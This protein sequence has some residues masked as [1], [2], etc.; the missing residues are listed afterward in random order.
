MTNGYKYKKTYTLQALMCKVQ[1]K[2]QR[3]QVSYKIYILFFLVFIIRFTVEQECKPHG[4]KDG[5]QQVRNADFTRP[6]EVYTDAEDQ[7]RSHVGQVIDSTRCHQ[8][9]CDVC[10]SSNDPLRNPYR[11]KGE[12]RTLPHRGYHNHN[13]DA[14]E[15][16]F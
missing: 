15:D 2:S 6:D 14:V 4:Y 3:I 8:R 1:Q 12:Q 10:H 16:T 9:C 13:N 7:N 5:W 11:N